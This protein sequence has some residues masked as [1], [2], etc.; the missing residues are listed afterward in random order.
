MTDSTKKQEALTMLTE[1]R[2]EQ[3]EDKVATAA[4]LLDD[5]IDDIRAIKDRAEKRTAPRE[6]AQHL[7][8]SLEALATQVRKLAKMTHEA[9]FELA[10]LDDLKV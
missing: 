3:A 1:L 8:G 7:T 10:L 5:L 9:D 4:E 2:R 6:K